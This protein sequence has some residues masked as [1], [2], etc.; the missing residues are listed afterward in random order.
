VSREFWVSSGHQLT[1]RAPDGRL[2]VTDELLGAYLARPELV[3]PP[4]A[5]A[6]E[7]RL[8]RFL[9]KEPRRPVSSQEIAALADAEAR[10]NWQAALAFRDRLIKA[11][12]IEGAYLDLVRNGPGATPPVFLDQLVHL[13]LRNALDECE[14]PY[15][16]RAAEL[17]FRRQRAGFQDGATLLADD[18]ALETRDAVFDSP[19]T[20]MLGGDPVSGL[21]VLTAE[22]AW[23]YWSRS[24]AFTMALNIGSDPRARAALAEVIALWVRHLL[25]VQT[26]VEPLPRIEDRDWRWFVGLDAEAT[27]IGN[28]LWCGESVGEDALSRIL[29]LFALRFADPMRVDARFGDRPVYLLLA[30]TPD[31]L[32]RMKP[33][34]LIAGLPLAAA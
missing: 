19:L 33:Q 32:V 7:R 20:A 12:T 10:E 15:L 13:I 26:G 25:G 30:M 1:G 3:P 8:H 11:G 29:A 16:L 28:A 14:D 22:N 2:A 21:D 5:C 18:E 6:A 17:F 34:N 23:T 24:D 4:E 31:R 27:R 9:L